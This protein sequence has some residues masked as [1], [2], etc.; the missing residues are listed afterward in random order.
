[1]GAPGALQWDGKYITVASASNAENIV[2]RVHIVGSSA[3]VVGTT[4]LQ[5]AKRVGQSWF[6]NRK[7]LATYATLHGS[8]TSWI[9]SWPYPK[10]GA[11]KS[12]VEAPRAQLYGLT[13][14]FAPHR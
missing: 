12:L 1:M 14:S 13:V 2:Y 6:L 8:K 10:G 11:V 5:S 4:A 9:G 7:I 3:H